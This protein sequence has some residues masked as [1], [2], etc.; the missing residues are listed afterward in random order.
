MKKIRRI[1]SINL[2]PLCLVFLFTTCDNSTDPEEKETKGNITGK[3]MYGMTALPSVYIF[4]GDSLRATTD[5]AG[6]YSI[7][8]LEEGSYNLLC[9]AINYRDTISQVQVSGGSTVTCDFDLIP[10]TTTGWIKGEFQDIIL[11]HDSLQN[12]PEMAYWNAE[13]IYQGTTGATLI[14]KFLQTYVADRWIYLGDSLVSKTDDWAMFSLKIQCGTYQLTGRCEGY[15][16]A[17]EVVTVL[18]GT[19]A[20]PRYVNFFMTRKSAPK[21]ALNRR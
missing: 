8:S 15:Y 20:N 21:L 13:Q 11:F 18:P 14:N 7:T 12:N 10:D 2:I 3:V 1:F 16:D 17:T 6:T 5:D 4:I 9:S 19:L